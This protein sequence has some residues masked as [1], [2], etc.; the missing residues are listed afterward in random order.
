VLPV[1]SIGYVMTALAGRFFLHEHISI[2]RWAGIGLIVLGVTLVARTS[3]HSA[4]NQPGE[5]R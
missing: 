5:G 3:P 2:W 1:T 4:M